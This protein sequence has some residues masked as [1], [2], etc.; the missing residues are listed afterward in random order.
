MA[1]GHKTGGRRKGSLNRATRAV[2]EIAERHTEDAIA[3]LV[4]V[5]RSKEA[6]HAAIVAAARELLDR[7][8]GKATQAVNLSGSLSL[9]ELVLQ[10][11]AGVS[12]TGDVVH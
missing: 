7:G 3:A 8:H 5:M 4:G 1:A 11:F 12:R 10:S 2:R 6:P 9:E